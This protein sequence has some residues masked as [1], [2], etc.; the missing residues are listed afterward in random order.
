LQEVGGPFDAVFLLNVLDRCARPHALLEH[1]HEL[2]KPEPSSESGEPDAGPDHEGGGDGRGGRLV[3]SFPLPS[4]DLPQLRRAK[5]WAQAVV[6]LQTAV[7]APAGWAI[8]SI[9]RAPYLSQGAV[10][11]VNPVFVLDAAVMVLRSTRRP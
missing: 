3:I 2:V 6:A 11:S 8:A 10:H 5:T 1:L 4:P 7:L 9:T